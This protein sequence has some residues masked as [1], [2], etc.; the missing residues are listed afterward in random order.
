M[1]RLIL[2]T[3][4]LGT[5]SACTDTDWS[6]KENERIDGFYNYIY[7]KELGSAIVVGC[8]G[9]YDIRIIT[10][11]VPASKIRIRFGTNQIVALEGRQRDKVLEVTNEKWV[12]NNL[13]LHETAIVEYT[14]SRGQVVTTKLG[15]KGFK[16]TFSSK[17]NRG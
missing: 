8:K 1:K 11:D 12:F 5:L 15:I 17:C 14:N 3:M 9:S 4:L 2:A 7:S 10:K 13:S 16:E 6:Y